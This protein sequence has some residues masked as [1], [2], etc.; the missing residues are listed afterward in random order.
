MRQNVPPE[1]KTQCPKWVNR[2]TLTLR[3]LLPLYPD[4]QTFSESV[5]MSQW[6]I[7][8]LTSKA[9]LHSIISS[10]M[11]STPGR[12]L[13]EFI[14]STR[15]YYL[16]RCLMLKSTLHSRGLLQQY[17]SIADLPAINTIE[18]LIDAAP[19]RIEGDGLSS[20]RLL[21]SEHPGNAGEESYAFT[22]AIRLV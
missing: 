14:I 4:K 11:E 12:H 19:H 22:C 16:P 20:F 1:R 18:L 9:Y 7:F 6:C 15:I 8:G 17:R 13:D 2:V 5:G 3:R 10:A 21:A